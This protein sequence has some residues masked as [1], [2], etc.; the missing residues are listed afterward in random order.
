MITT[1]DQ[2]VP[3]ASRMCQI[4]AYLICAHRTLPGACTLAKS[5]KSCCWKVS[6]CIANC[7]N[8]TC[9]VKGYLAAISA[10]APQSAHTTIAIDDA[11]KQSPVTFNNSLIVHS[12]SSMP[13]AFAKHLCQH[14]IVHCLL[15]HGDCD[16]YRHK[17]WICR[18][19]QAAS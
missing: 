3:D 15:W 14:Q 16:L 2:D 17:S 6:E 7:S 9:M 18:N 11:R 13:V 5:S 8:V 19:K 1:S 10:R 4:C 12:M